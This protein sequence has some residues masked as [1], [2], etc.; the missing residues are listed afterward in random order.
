MLTLMPPRRFSQLRPVLRPACFSLMLG[1][2]ALAQGDG[3]A[4]QLGKG[5]QAQHKAETGRAQHRA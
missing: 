5:W 2:P 3:L 4:G 1:L